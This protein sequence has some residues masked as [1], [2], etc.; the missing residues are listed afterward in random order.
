MRFI[1]ITEPTFIPNE[2][3]I[4]AKLLRLGVDLVHIRKLEATAEAVENLI[5]AIPVEYHTRLVLHDNFELSARFLLYGLHLNR[6]NSVLP[7]GFKGSV[8][9]SCHTFEEVKT[10]KSLCDYVFLSPIFDSIS[11][12]GYASSFTPQTLLT[13]Q[14]QGIIDEKVVALGGITAENIVPI[15][16]YGFGGVALLGDVWNRINDAN[17]DDYIKK[18][19]TAAAKP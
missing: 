2:A 10:Y 5:K 13:A 7:K 1:V 16:R 12:Q 8:S 17:F 4:I 9:R 18:I 14:K 15:Q 6:R 3:T 19:A 11:K